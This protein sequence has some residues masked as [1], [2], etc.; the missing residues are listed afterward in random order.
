MNA[1]RLSLV[2]YC[3]PPLRYPQSVQMGRLARHFPG[4]VRVFCGEEDT[5]PDLSLLDGLDRDGLAIVRIPWSF[6]AAAIKQLR[7]FTIR[8]RM[9]F[10]DA[11]RPWAKAAT[12]KIVDAEWHAGDVLMTTGQPMSDHLIGLEVKRTAGVP[13]IVHLSDPW[14][15]NPYRSVSAP[16]RTRNLRLEEEVLGLAD[17]VVVTTE[18]TGELLVGN[19]PGLQLEIAVIPHSFEPSLYPPHTERREEGVLVRHLGNFYGSRTP[20][21]LLA[22]LDL[23]NRRDPRVLGGVRVE[24]IGDTPAASQRSPYLGDLREIVSFSP[25]VEYRTSLRLMVESDL[26]LLVDAPGPNSLF[27]PS[28]LVDYLGAGRPIVA[29]TPP[30]AAARTV[31]D[32][33]GWVGDPTDVEGSAAALESALRAVTSTGEE[34]EGAYPAAFSSERVA[35]RYAD[36]AQRLRT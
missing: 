17:A 16:V 7:R 21:P 14:V 30:G 24:L 34:P 12:P 9:L 1:P 19:H 31:R 15:D 10:P 13:W 25:P 4:D 27:L 32:R 3:F 22:A 8:Q 11:Y 2:S 18:E 29:L 26:L 33:G 20:E 35:A 23:I 36:L 28:K 5:A 6:P